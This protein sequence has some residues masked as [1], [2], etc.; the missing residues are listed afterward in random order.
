MW[1]IGRPVL[2]GVAVGGVIASLLLLLM[3]A[4]MT[5]WDVPQAAVTPMATAAAAIGA[6]AG[7]FTAARIAKRQGL[8]LGAICGALLY[9]LIWLTG[10]A[11]AGDMQAASILIKWAILI[12]CGAVGG[13]SGVNSGRRPHR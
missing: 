12:A 4:G 3:A 9:A 6:F 2:W 13:I 8:L 7:G 10:L 11:H 5:A 1:R